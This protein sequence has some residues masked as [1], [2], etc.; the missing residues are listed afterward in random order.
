MISAE[1][2]FNS[3]QLQRIKL[4]SKLDI[5]AENDNTD[6]DCC[7][8]D[9]KDSESDLELIEMCFEGASAL[10]PTEKSMLYYICGYVAF[11]EGIVC[12][13]D[14]GQASLSHPKPSLQLNYHVEN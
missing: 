1:Q 4:F 2:V 7:T 6:N 8:I 9:L 12:S 5:R 10:N 11:K 14:I 13:D 3:L